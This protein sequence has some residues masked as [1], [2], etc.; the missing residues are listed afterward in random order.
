MSKVNVDQIKG[1]AT[2]GVGGVTG[3]TGPIGPTGPQGPPG[4][5]GP[6]GPPGTGVASGITAQ[7]FERI[8]LF[9]GS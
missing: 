3:P 1:I 7:S 2:G 8:F 4:V 5:T 6:V 9:M